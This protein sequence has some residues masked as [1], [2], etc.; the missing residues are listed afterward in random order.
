LIGGTKA[1]DAQT[2]W[3]WWFMWFE[4]LEHNTLC[5]RENESCILQALAFSLGCLEWPPHA[6]PVLMST[7]AFYSSMSGSYNETQDRQ[8]APRQVKP[9]DVFNGV[10]MPGLVAATLHSVSSVVPCCQ[11]AWHCSGVRRM[12][13]S[14][15]TT[16]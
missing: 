9:Y 13:H 2:R 4:S 8:V 11:V 12:V 16:L 10:G 7:R 14:A 1:L 5:P 6:S 3:T 15:G